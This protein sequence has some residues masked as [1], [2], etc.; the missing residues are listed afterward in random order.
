MWP[1]QPENSPGKPRARRISP[2]RSPSLFRLF[3][4]TTCWSSWFHLLI[5]LFEKNTAVPCTSF[6]ECP[7]VPLLLSK[8]K[9]SF[10]LSLDSALHILKAS[11]RSCLFHLS[12]SDH[13]FNWCNLSSCLSFHIINHFRQSAGDLSLRRRKLIALDWCHHR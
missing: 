11:M 13:S 2:W 5:T 9:S 12:S 1:H 7:L 4:S 10:S 3:Y 8:V 6:Q